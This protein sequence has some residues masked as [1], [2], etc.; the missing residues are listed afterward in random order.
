VTE[1][2]EIKA[3]FGDFACLIMAVAISGLA[4][5]AIVSNQMMDERHALCAVEQLAKLA[6]ELRGGEELLKSWAATQ[7]LDDDKNI[8]DF[9]EDYQDTFDAGIKQGRINLAR[10]ILQLRREQKNEEARR[11]HGYQEWNAAQSKDRSGGVPP[12]SKG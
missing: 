6:R 7:G 5:A 3:A 8:T 11:L 12:V 10:E 1:V 4:D 2:E 9:P